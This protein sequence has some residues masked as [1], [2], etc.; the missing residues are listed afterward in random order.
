M[1][2]AVLRFE[3][4]MRNEWIKVRTFDNLRRALECGINVAVGAQRSL[5]LFFRQGFGLLRKSR[6]TLRR[7]RAFVPLHFQFLF[8]RSGLP[9]A[10]GNDRD[11]AEQTAKLRSPVYDG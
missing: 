8:G 9:P 2:R 6:T 4:R 5:R 10:I 7:S 1:R 3:R 11:A